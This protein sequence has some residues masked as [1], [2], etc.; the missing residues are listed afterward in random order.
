MGARLLNTTSSERLRVTRAE[1]IA[2]KPYVACHTF[3]SGLGTKLP[4][5]YSNHVVHLQSLVHANMRYTRLPKAI[6]SSS[7]GEPPPTHPSD[8]HPP[9]STL[10]RYGT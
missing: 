5:G 1:A 2:L 3:F 8:P 9:T 4:Q 7:N 6:T 10:P